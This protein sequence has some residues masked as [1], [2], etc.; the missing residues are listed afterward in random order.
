MKTSRLVLTVICL[1]LF[2][3]AGLALTIRSRFQPSP[4]AAVTL[5]ISRPPTELIAGYRQWTRVN[6]TPALVAAP[7]AQLCAIPTATAAPGSPHG[8]DK[9]I[10]VYVNEIGRHAMMEE[11]TPHFPQGSIV[12]KEKLTTA[13]S[14]DPELLTVM[15]KR[16]GGYNPDSGDWE[17]LVFDGR[18]KSVQARGKLENCQACHKMDA[19]TDYISRSYLPMA[20]RAKLK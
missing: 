13:T 7:N 11:K 14:T 17:Y 9:Y 1:F 6:P 12:I 19:E 5:D 3:S 15:I 4:R 2:L 16:E 8:P 18:G 10:T 20:V